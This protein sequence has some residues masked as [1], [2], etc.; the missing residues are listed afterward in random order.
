MWFDSPEQRGNRYG[1][2]VASASPIAPIKYPDDVIEDS[3][4]V[5][6]YEDDDDDGIVLAESSVITEEV[7]ATGGKSDF[8][9]E[10]VPPA[11]PVIDDNRNAGGEF[12]TSLPKGKT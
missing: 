11:L 1:A 9:H 3:A 12:S 5:D 7:K 10:S 2:V 6:I 4:D 8:I